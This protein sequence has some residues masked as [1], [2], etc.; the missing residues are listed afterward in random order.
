M[1][2]ERFWARVAKGSPEECWV[3]QGK[4]SRDGYGRFKCLGVTY[5]PHAFVWRLLNGEIAKGKQVNHRCDNRGCVNPSHLYQ[6]TQA[7]NMRDKVARNRQATGWNNGS[8]TKPE[9]RPR[10]ERVGGAKLT[11]EKVIAIRASENSSAYLARVYGV[12]KANIGMIRARKTWAHI[13]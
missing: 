12:T 2:E 11:A 9:R 4:L 13:Q 6:G 10:G 1:I 3:W 5:R 8:H 7:D